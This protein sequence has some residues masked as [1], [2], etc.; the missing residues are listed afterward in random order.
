MFSLLTGRDGDPLDVI[1]IGTGKYQ[2]GDVVVVK[3]LGASCHC[4]FVPAS[5]YAVGSLCIGDATGAD[6]K[7]RVIACCPTTCSQSHA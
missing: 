3:L 5:S 6:W 4:R 2:V 7:V 1:E